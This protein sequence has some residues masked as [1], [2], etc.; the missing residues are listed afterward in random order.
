MISV[1]VCSQISDQNNWRL[2]SKKDVLKEQFHNLQNLSQIYQVCQQF[3]GE[4]DLAA[5][6][7]NC[8][9]CYGDIFL[10]LYYFTLLAHQ[11]R[12]SRRIQTS[13]SAATPFATFSKKCF[14]TIHNEEMAF[15][16]N[17]TLSFLVLPQGQIYA[18]ISAT[19]CP[20]REP[21]AYQ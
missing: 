2:A 15:V 13:F 1:N 8:L 4:Y 11:E 6:A 21:H 18:P 14:N 20:T 12:F 7:L 19:V 16:C 5:D 10:F 17:L 9:I 3:Q